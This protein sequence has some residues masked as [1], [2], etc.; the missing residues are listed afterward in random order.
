MRRKIDRSVKRFRRYGIVKSDHA[1]K[2]LKGRGRLNPEKMTAKI[3]NVYTITYPTETNK[4]YSHWS[5]GLVMYIQ[6]NGKTIKLNS[7]EI[8]DLV[9]SLP[10]T[11]G[12]SY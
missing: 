6:K 3:I 5:D 8:Q 11:M 9:K 2:P 4:G 7:E 12:G 1:V 10:R